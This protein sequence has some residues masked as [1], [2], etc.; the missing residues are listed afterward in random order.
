MASSTWTPTATTGL[1]LQQ[2]QSQSQQYLCCRQFDQRRAC[3][4]STS[5]TAFETAYTQ[6]IDSVI[7]IT[8]PV[9]VMG[10]FS[11]PIEGWDLFEKDFISSLRGLDQPVGQHQQQDASSAPQQQTPFS[12]HDL[13]L[14]DPASTVSPSQLSLSLSTSDVAEFTSPAHNQSGGSARLVSQVSGSGPVADRSFSHLV[15]DTSSVDTWSPLFDTQM[16]QDLFDPVD[17]T[18]PSAVT[19]EIVDDPLKGISLEQQLFAALSASDS[20]PPLEFSDSELSS[21][22]LFSPATTF[23]LSPQ[24][25]PVTPEY[26]P[27]SS[28]SSPQTADAVLCTQMTQ[29]SGYVPK[30]YKVTKS[31][32]SSSSPAPSRCESDAAP[33]ESSA[34]ETSASDDTAV[35]R[36]SRRARKEPLPA[37]QFDPEDPVAAKRAR[38]TLAAR[39]SRARRQKQEEW[40]T[41]RIRELEE[42]VKE[43][44]KQAS[45]WKGKAVAAGVDAASCEL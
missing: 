35:P 41:K 45:F 37:I 28:Q 19:T 33:G 2:D 40:S 38:N 26:I 14:S 20:L 3:V 34:V 7:A 12:T 30:P 6:S 17:F 39:K 5:F 21:S 9:T 32:A 16:S 42:Q 8:P 23:S 25:K 15:P 18:A 29:N 11:A 31:R 36:I 43:L 22:G 13:I 10:Q 4:Q 44:Q 27:M 24:Q 1:S